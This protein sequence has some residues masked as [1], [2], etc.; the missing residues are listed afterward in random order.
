MEETKPDKTLDARGLLCPMPV[1]KV[2]QVIKEVPEGG[3][4]EV[5]ATDPGSLSDIPA[6]AKSQGHEII[7]IKREQDFIRFLIRRVK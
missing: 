6:W 4:L 2:S 7:D 1:V 3:I 5:L